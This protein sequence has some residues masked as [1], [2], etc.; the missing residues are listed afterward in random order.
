MVE[1]VI[2]PA[3]LDANCTRNEGRRV[4]EDLAVEEPTVDEI[5]SAVQQVGYDAVIER[6]KTYPRE[7]EPRGR[8][9]VKG[10]DDASKSDL[11]EAVAAY[12]TAIRE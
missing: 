5:A 4:A 1:N 7:Y 2:W 11:L 12:V 10:A 3:Y 8:V 6:S 9:V